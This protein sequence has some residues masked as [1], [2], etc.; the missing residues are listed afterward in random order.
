MPSNVSFQSVGFS[1]VTTLVRQPQA[2]RCDTVAKRI[3][4]YSVLSSSPSG[5]NSTN[6]CF[7]EISCFMGPVLVDEKVGASVELAVMLRFHVLE[8]GKSTRLNSSHLGI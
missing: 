3:E 6:W 7:S 5:M 1:G 8:I 2:Q 4:M